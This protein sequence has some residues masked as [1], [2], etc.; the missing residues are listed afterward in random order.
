M[1]VTSFFFVDVSR[2]DKVTKSRAR[3][4][5]LKGKNAG[6]KLGHRLKTQCEPDSIRSSNKLVKKHAVACARTDPERGV[7]TP[8]SI[9]LDYSPFNTEL[10]TF[11]YSVDDALQYEYLI[12]SCK[13]DLPRSI[14]DDSPILVLV[15]VVEALYPPRLCQSLHKPRAY[16][17]HMFSQDQTCTYRAIPPRRVA[18]K[19]P[20]PTLRH[21]TTLLPG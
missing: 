14:D 10:I 4:H 11:T 5:V 6:R 13:I 7:S 18:A 12:K 15:H 2:T 21:R 9:P 16:W 20:S 3:S 17:F 8:R 19:S 1:A